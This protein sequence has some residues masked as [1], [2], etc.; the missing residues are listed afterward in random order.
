MT[1]NK[2][3][4]GALAGV[5]T[6]LLFLIYH[7]LT[8]SNIWF[9]A[10]FMLIISALAGA[11]LI[12]SYERL[13]DT[14]SL[15]SWAAYTIYFTMG[16]TFLAILSV[17]IFNPVIT[18]EVILNLGGAPPPELIQGAFPLTVVWMIIAGVLPPLVKSRSLEGV[19]L[20]LGTSAALY[21]TLGLNL[22][23][24][25]KVEI[26]PQHTYLVEKFIIMN[27]GLGLVF[28]IISALLYRI[29]DS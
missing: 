11:L 20:T 2:A 17:L 22:S 15:K 4:L 3:A 19:G 16:L 18:S 27:I 12:V 29:S 23:I 8:I 13:T 1:G 14:Y 24:L 10:V 21:L 28:L 6:C 9:S 26:S 25:G 5:I 7:Q